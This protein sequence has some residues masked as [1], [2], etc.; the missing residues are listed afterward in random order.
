MKIGCVSL[1][2]LGE[3]L[4]RR[5]MSRHEL[6]LFGMSGQAAQDFKAAGASVAQDLP[7]L[8][9]SCDVIVVCARASGGDLRDI[10]FEGGRLIDGL[11]PGKIVVDLT[12]GDPGQTRTLSDELEKLGIQLVDA[13]VHSESW[14]DLEGSAALLC[15]GAAD[16]IRRVQALLES[17]TSRIVQTGAAGSGHAAYLVVQAIAAC[18][19]LVTYECAAMG[20]K[21]GLLVEDMA[22]V[23]NNSSGR[24]S[25]SERILPLLATGGRTADMQ[26]G[27]MVRELRLASRMAA[28]CGAPVLVGNLVRSFYEAAANEMGPASQLD[29]M[30][31]FYESMSGAH[32]WM[33]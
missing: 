23:L 30:A 27:H 4:V 24:S 16:A 32:F 20:A 31:R 3:T 18:N 2:S 28:S 5:L 26:I 14:D 10:L 9:S 33:A 8:A 11:S 17:I 22:T 19:R 21:Q 15:G 25:A 29:D 13:P 6:Q 7:A 1:Q 12:S